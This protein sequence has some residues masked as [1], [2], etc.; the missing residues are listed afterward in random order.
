MKHYAHGELN[1]FESNGNV[2]KGAK[3]VRAAQGK[4]IIAES[5]TTG[6]HH[7]LKADDGVKLFEKDGIMYLKNDVPAE[8][9]CV[10]KERHDEITLDPGIWEIEPAKEYDYYKEAHRNVAD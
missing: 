4:Y 2:P 10:L 1:F 6:N 5:E 8:V 3:V 7:C 9:F